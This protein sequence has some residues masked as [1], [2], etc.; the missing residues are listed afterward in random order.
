[1]SG[2]GLLIY[3]AT[4]YTGEL[5]AREAVRGGLHPILAGRNQAQHFQFP[6]NRPHPIHTITTDPAQL[7]SNRL[8]LVFGQ[9]MLRCRKIDR[10]QVRH[11]QRFRSQRGNQW[12][13]RGHVMG[14]P[15][16]SR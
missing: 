14:K 15:Y 7:S 3:G 13:T 6:L 1:M 9:C 10:S 8:F 5:I 12:S 11:Q 16:P 2:A 4:G